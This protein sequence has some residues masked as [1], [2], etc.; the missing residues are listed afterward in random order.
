MRP[1]GTTTFV[2]ACWTVPVSN[3]I[4]PLKR[5]IWQACHLHTAIGQVGWE[6][7]QL[8]FLFPKHSFTFHVH[9]WV[10]VQDECFQRRDSPNVCAISSFSFTIQCID[11]ANTCEGHRD[12]EGSMIQPRRSCA[13][14][15]LLCLW[16]WPFGPPYKHLTL[17]AKWP[18]L[19]F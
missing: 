12:Q 4:L 17:H 3:P 1:Y 8:S 11:R 15:L 7:W 16:A 18:N 10:N 13:G 2:C 5:A 6:S 9:I 14:R 19:T